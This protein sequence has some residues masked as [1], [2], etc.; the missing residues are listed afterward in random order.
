VSCLLCCLCDLTAPL[1]APSPPLLRRGWLQ[2]AT[3][4]ICATD[5]V[6]EGLS[7]DAFALFRTF[8]SLGMTCRMHERTQ[9]R[10]RTHSLAGALQRRRQMS[11]EQCLSTPEGRASDRTHSLTS[12]GASAALL[13]LVVTGLFIGFGISPV[14]GIPNGAGGTTST[15]AQ[16]RVSHPVQR[17]T[18][19]PPLTPSLPGAL[20][21]SV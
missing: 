20:P 6:K 15:I 14:L 9:F 7:A 12:A 10:Q 3:S 1:P 2:T 5:F 8:Q 18:I 16:L 11:L 21:V 17:E 4:A 19:Q 13:S